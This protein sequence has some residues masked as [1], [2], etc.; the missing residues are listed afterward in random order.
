[1]PQATYRYNEDETKCDVEIGD[2]EFPDVDVA[3]GGMVLLHDD[4]AAK[5]YA[6]VIDE[7]DLESDTVYEL[8]PIETAE[9]GEDEETGEAPEPGPT[10]NGY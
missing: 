4:E 10:A 6:F 1:M 5:H 9:A 3:D 7:E 2:C 8:V